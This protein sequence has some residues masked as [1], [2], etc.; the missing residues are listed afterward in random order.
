VRSLP[1]E[2]DSSEGPLPRRDTTS[3][4]VVAWGDPAVVLECG[5]GAAVLEGPVLTLGPDERT[6]RQFLTDDVGSATAYTT[7]DLA[8]DVRVTVPDAYDAT[9]LV[10]LVPLLKAHLT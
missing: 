8:V 1:R 4:L 10:D 3:D 2:L 6:T 9:L 7:G 5:V